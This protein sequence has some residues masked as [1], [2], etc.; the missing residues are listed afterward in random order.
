MP[1]L[2]ACAYLTLRKPKPIGEVLMEITVRKVNFKGIQTKEYRRTGI[3]GHAF[4]EV[5]VSLA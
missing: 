2:G 4:C 3:S 1:A 5:C